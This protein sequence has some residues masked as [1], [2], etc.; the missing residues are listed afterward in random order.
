MDHSDNEEDEEIRR[1]NAYTGAVNSI[2]S[3]HQRTWYLSLDR[4]N[5]GFQRVRGPD[6]FS[7]ERVSRQDKLLGFEP[8][9]V[10]GRDVERSVVTGR[11][12][13]EVLADEGVIGY[14]PRQGWRPVLE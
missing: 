11:L 7:W 12:G 8:F 3:V 13:P 1:N 5:S 4:E 14:I 9:Y 2:G 6:G 10:Q